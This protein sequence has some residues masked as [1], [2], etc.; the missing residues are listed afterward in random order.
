VDAAIF[1][2][3]VAV[4]RPVVSF[5]DEVQAD[6]EAL[7]RT[8]QALRLAQAASTATLVQMQHP[9]WDADEIAA[10]VALVNAEACMAV[11]DPFAGPAVP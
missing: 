11:P 1:H 2:S 5:A 4:E 9:D 7:A 6:P 3:R 10:E 8:A